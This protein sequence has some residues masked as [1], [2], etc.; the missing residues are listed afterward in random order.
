MN[1]QRTQSVS[2]QQFRPGDDNAAAG[3]SI[4]PHD[5]L[6]HYC[7][8][9]RFACNCAEVGNEAQGFVIRH[10]MSGESSWI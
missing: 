6:A 9:G 3:E 5:M 8:P 7:V 4:I 1:L 2:L 10:F